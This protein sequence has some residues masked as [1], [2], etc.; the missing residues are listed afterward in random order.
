MARPKPSAPAERVALYDAQIA[1]HP[2]IDR[3]GAANPYTSANGHMFSCI[4]KVGDVGLRLSKEDREHFLEMY[5][6]ELLVSYNTIMKEYVVVPDV[7]L[8]SIEKF[9]PYLNLS[10]DYVR[11]LK[12]KPTTKKKK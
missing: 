4:N 6:T 9:Q 12:P 5:H 3:K 10:F 11:S 8:S 1:A 7:L 2:E